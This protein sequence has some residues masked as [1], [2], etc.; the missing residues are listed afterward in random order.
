MR[1]EARSDVVSTGLLVFLFCV[2][3]SCDVLLSSGL[4]VSVSLGHW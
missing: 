1:S 4:C 2:F 3:S